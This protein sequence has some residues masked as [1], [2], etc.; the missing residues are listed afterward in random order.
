MNEDER[1]QEA[2]FRHSMIIH[3]PDSHNHSPTPGL[4]SNHVKPN[5]A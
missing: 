1:N 4:T 5:S 3:P 2:L